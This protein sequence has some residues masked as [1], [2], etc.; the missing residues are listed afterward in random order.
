M[1][2]GKSSKL[3]VSVKNQQ[4]ANQT[5]A[6]FVNPLTGEINFAERAGVKHLDLV[7]SGEY[8]MS[9]PLNQSDN[10]DT[11][12]PVCIQTAKRNTQST[13]IQVS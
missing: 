2:L 8:F 12:S 1:I 4:H 7:Q 11:L 3:Q 6:F 10:T 9:V 13:T 5:I